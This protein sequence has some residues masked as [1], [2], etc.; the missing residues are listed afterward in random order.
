MKSVSLTSN[1]FELFDIPVSFTIDLTTLAEKYRTLQ[2]LAHPDNFASASDQQRRLSVQQSAQINE[3]YHTLKDPLAR[4]KYLLL[5]NG[6]DISATKDTIMSPEFLMQQMDLRE[7]L[8]SIKQSDDPV[9]A[10]MK[11]EGEIDVSANTLISDIAARFAT[12]N[13]DGS[14][15]SH[16]LESIREKVHRLQFM[17]K[18]RSE[19]QSMEESLM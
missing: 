5:L 13:V 8:A 3:A 6:M 1:Y 14:N 2:H 15:I 9:D 16:D 17:N 4:A 12:L 11:L 10:L 19:V 7:R 18:L